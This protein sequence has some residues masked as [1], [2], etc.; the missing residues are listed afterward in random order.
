MRRAVYSL[1]CGSVWITVQKEN[2]TQGWLPSGN[3][4]LIVGFHKTRALDVLETLRSTW[5]PMAE[6][7]TDNRNTSTFELKT[8]GM[9]PA[10]VHKHTKPTSTGHEAR[11]SG[12]NERMGSILGKVHPGIYGRF[13]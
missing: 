5:P 2:R 11:P 8:Q 10:I 4:V 9:Y 6:V 13:I 7:V 1:Y 3:I 12:T